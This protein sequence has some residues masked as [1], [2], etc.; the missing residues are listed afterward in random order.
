[1]SGAVWG[2]VCGSV[3]CPVSGLV[4]VWGGVS[5]RL[6]GHCEG[7]AIAHIKLISCR[8]V[9]SAT[10]PK[11]HT[12]TPVT[13]HGGCWIRRRC[14]N[15]GVAS[16]RS[17]GQG[18]WGRAVSCRGRAPVVDALLTACRRLWGRRVQCEPQEPVADRTVPRHV[19]VRRRGRQMCAEQG[20]RLVPDRCRHTPPPGATRGLCP[21]FGVPSESD[22]VKA[23]R[24]ALRVTQGVWRS[25]TGPGPAPAMKRP[26]ID[27]PVRGVH[28]GP[29]GTRRSPAPIARAGL[30]HC[31]P[32]GI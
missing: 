3:S 23:A 21:V 28:C 11:T 8:G 16:R 7:G 15:G 4:G 13:R 10:V 2:A 24:G 26:R 22:A 9:V 12:V 29:D 20:P 19:T 17:A 6:C 5:D 30:L 25:R 32:D 31:G 1:M 27:C 18:C 14:A